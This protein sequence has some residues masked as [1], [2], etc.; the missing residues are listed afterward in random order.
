MRRERQLDL[1]RRAKESGER[2]KGLQAPASR[3]NAAT[4]YTDHA[5]FDLE[6]QKLFRE[7]AV[8]FGLSSDLAE[9]G[10]YRAM[11]VDGLPLVVVRQPDGSLA[12]HINAC[13]HRGSP[14]VEPSG[15][16]SGLR[17]LTCPY[18]A[19]TYD[20]DGSLKARPATAGAFDDVAIDCDLLRRPVGEK[21]G[22]IFVRPE[23]EERVDVDE[24]LCG[25]QDDLASF[26]F[27]SYVHIETR[28]DEWAMNWKL[29]FD[30]F[31]ETYHIR[32][33][34]KDSIAPLFNSDCLISEGFGPH[35]LSLGLRSDIH[36]ELSKPEDEWSMLRQGTIQYFL[37]PNGM[38]VH[39][40]DH[41]EVWV[42][43]PLAVNRSRLSVSVYA[44]NAP[45]TQKAHHYFVKNLDLVAEVTGTEDFAL[46]EQIQESL[47]AGALPE[48]V[49]G[50][51]EPPLIYFHD[52]IDHALGLSS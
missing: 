41:L 17:V 47:D 39:Q 27:D 8:F 3:T 5:R 1:L 34:H 22:L 51:I 28:T 30:T 7:R 35:V 12:A 32:T 2:F 23:G 36:E 33:L 26:G 14:L 42:V 31:A 10:S 37:S 52:Q 25:A 49:Y 9:P 46:M 13:R 40:V 48:L 44:P 29:F 21:Y 50:R 19:W 6:M 15:T 38:I 43:E 4:A 11:R 18:H 20:L 45:E 16:G 24:V